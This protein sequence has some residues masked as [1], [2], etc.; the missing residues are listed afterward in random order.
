MHGYFPEI[1]PAGVTEFEDPE[2]DPC[3]MVLH[4]AALK[5]RHL[6]ALH[7]D[8]LVLGADTTVAIDGRVLNKPAGM[9]EARAMLHRLSGRV[10]TVFTGVAIVWNA[11]AIDKTF[12][13][14][15]RVRFK[16]LTDA[17]IT[18]YFKIVNPLDRA[19]AYGIQDGR[20]LI[21]ASHDPPISNIMGLP[22]ERVVPLLEELGLRP[23]L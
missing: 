8:A 9:E 19:G 1:I 3:A 17:I 13:I 14:Q 7:P 6:A 21:I 10:H 2:A 18:G 12:H 16:P 20:E 23:R 5:A 4:N 22:V 11:R 15:N